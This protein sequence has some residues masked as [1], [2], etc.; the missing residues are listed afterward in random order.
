MDSPITPN[1]MAS[2]VTLSSAES[3]TPGP[4]L[5]RGHTQP[6]S[7]PVSRGSC[8][9]THSN[10]QSARGSGATPTVKAPKLP[11]QKRRR[12]APSPSQWV[13]ATLQN[14]NLL[15]EDSHRS[16]SIPLPP[17]RP[18]YPKEERDS[19]NE[20]IGVAPYHPVAWNGT[21]PGP[22]LGHG[23]GLGGKDLRN[24]ELGGRGGVILGRVLVC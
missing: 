8:L 11:G 1:P 16:T 15:S 4:E 18:N 10:T 3:Y 6:Y 2:T 17:V 22:G 5:R 13:P 20:N 23:I 14:L 24:I 9:T 7:L 12:R 21:L 19:W